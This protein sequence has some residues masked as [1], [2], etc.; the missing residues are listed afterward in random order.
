MIMDKPT[1]I[2]QKM[3]IIRTRHDAMTAGHPGIDKTMELITRDFTWK[4]L[5][6]DVT[7][8]VHNCNICK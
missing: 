4:G 5:R 1:M 7:E 8:Y 2:E 3:E 6:D